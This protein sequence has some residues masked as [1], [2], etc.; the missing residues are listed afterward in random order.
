MTHGAFRKKNERPSYLSDFEIKKRDVYLIC[1]FSN[2]L[3][4]SCFT[5]EFSFLTKKVWTPLLQV[6]VFGNGLSH[7]VLAYHCHQ[8]LLFFRL[9]GN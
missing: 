6:E 7:H 9:D 8:L 5:C 1:A 3:S 4:F 2:H